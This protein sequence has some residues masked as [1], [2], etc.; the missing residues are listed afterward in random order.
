MLSFFPMCLLAIH[1]FFR[2]MSIRVLRPLFNQVFG[3]CSI[4]SLLSCL[5]SLCML[6]INSLPDARSAV[7]F[8]HSAGRLC[9]WLAASPAVRNLFS[10]MRPTCP[11]LLLWSVLLA[12]DPRNHRQGQRCEV[13]CIFYSWYFTVSSL[14]SE[15]FVHI[16]L[17]LC[18]L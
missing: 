5:S 6:D 9:A 2:E 17:V 14:S 3:V 16:E 18:V 4:F 13:F 12:S 10:W 1:V 7:T 11:F 15:S 8:P